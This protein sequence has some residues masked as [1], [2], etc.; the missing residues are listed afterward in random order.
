MGADNRVNMLYDEALRRVS[1]GQQQWR[2]VCKLAG[3]LYRYEFDNIL[4]VYMQRPEATLAADYDT[5]K[6]VGRYVKRGSRGIAV[7]PSRVL[8]P[9]VRYVFDISDTGGREQELTWRLD[10]SNI[11]A[12]ADYLRNEGIWKEKAD[13]GKNT[14]EKESDL[15]LIKSF[16]DGQI[17]VIMNSE[18]ADRISR[19]ADSAGKRSRIAVELLTRSVMSAVYTRCGFELPSQVQDLSLIREFTPGEAACM[20][21]LV[22]DISCEVLKGIARDL[23]QIQ[24]KERRAGYGRNAADIP[25]GGGRDVLPGPGTSGGEGVNDRAGEVRIPGGGIP[26]GEPQRP[27]Q[28]AGAS[29]NA[30]RDNAG[31][32]GGSVQHDG[33]S[34][35]GLPGKEPAAKPGVHDGN[36]AAAGTGADAGRGDRNVPDRDE[37]PLSG[38]SFSEDLSK[39]NPVK[40][41]PV[42]ENLAKETVPDGEKGSF[43]QASFFIEPD[44]S[45]GMPEKAE[46]VLIVPH[47][48][49]RHALMSD[50]GFIYG[51]RRIYETFHKTSS[52]EERINAV[53]KLYGESGRS[54][55]W[56]GTALGYDT[57]CQGGMHFTWSE[58]GTVKEGHVNWGAIVQELD[59]LV[60]SGEYYIPPADFDPDRVSSRLWQEPADHFFNG[61]FWQAFPNAA[62]KEVVQQ[63]IPLSDKMQFVERVFTDKSLSARSIFENQYGKC[64]VE[65]NWDGITIDFSDGN[66]KKWRA[67]LD[68]QDC[69]AYISDMVSCGAYHTECS[70]AQYEGSG[71]EKKD[72]KQADGL[73]KY[74]QEFLAG[75]PEIR[76]QRRVELL[77]RVLESAGFADISAAWNTSFDKAAIWNGDDEWHGRRVYEYIAGNCPGLKNCISGEEL[78]Q[79]RHDAAASLNLNKER[80]LYR[81]NL[82][83]TTAAPDKV[84]ANEEQ[85][86][87]GWLMRYFREEPGY[88]AVQTLVYDI[89]TTN[90]DMKTK[91]DFL[92][93]IYGRQHEGFARLE[94]T[95]GTGGSIRRD[96][97]GITVSYIKP[98]GT[99]G[100]H[101]ADYGYCAAL[102]M[103][104]IEE[105]EYLG[106]GIYERF[107]ETPQS[108]MAADW[109]MEI[110]HKYQEKMEAEPNFTALQLPETWE[111]SRVLQEAGQTQKSETMQS[112]V[113][114]AGET[115]IKQS[116]EP[117]KTEAAPGRQGTEPAVESPAMQP[118]AVSETGQKA[119]AGQTEPF[120]IQSGPKQTGAAGLEGETIIRPDIP[121]VQPE[122]ENA[123]IR[124]AGGAVRNRTDADGSESRQTSGGNF[125]FDGS[126]IKKSTLPKSSLPK[127]GKAGQKTRYRWN[128]EAVR[129]LKKI[130][131]EDRPATPEEQE[132]LARYVGWG[133]IPQAFDAKNENWQKEYA[134]LKELLS[135]REYNDAR[136]SVNTAFYTDPVITSAIHAALKQFGFHGG[137]IL[138]PA[139][140]TGNFFGSLPKEFSGSRLYGV[141]KD[142]ISG[143]I[144]QLL[145]PEA[146]ISIR[147][148]EEKQYPDNFFDVAVG[149]VPFGDYSLYDKRYAK[150][151]FRIHDYFFGATRS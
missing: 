100:E 130:E 148:F 80:F 67:S 5:W 97:D 109:F 38:N 13:S 143:R 138:E 25:R 89:F 87:T 26:E 140:G 60:A 104:M 40:D 11:P 123:E 47:E 98:D 119:E 93:D 91:A 33:A 51:K 74:T 114:D 129:L 37:V 30:G 44:G 86:W 118:D 52:T 46:A 94:K 135:D 24:E 81:K 134:E 34:G 99:A 61:C 9:E 107:Q 83:E 12:Y 115:E 23:K 2:E 19:F 137:S 21:N 49:I 71:A 59:A 106:E 4:M 6:K 141:E 20:G 121:A 122:T 144:A 132:I 112:D 57:Y 150:Y 65:C 48:C 66:G 32:G 8:K 73:K 102:V 90:L 16:T 63:D 103:R 75:T 113:V 10:G 108:F 149:N 136:D 70:Y 126:D 120:E 95:E 27:L 35:K 79:F 31:G 92:A 14:M 54:I 28:N 41:N 88:T 111:T 36:V 133:G 85:L 145:Y 69:T 17:R 43:E 1:G 42:E 146:D 105:D 147:G 45:V 142:S 64:R 84:D 50:S 101:R 7:F 39:E 139:M 3:Q 151:K 77:R 62:L 76:Q 18:F 116:A 58:K 15:E 56:N 29:G 68:W 72:G 96:R 110:Y 22:S 53:K 128:V 82:A 55:E 127:D 125:H 78:G 117:G 131:Y 124:Q